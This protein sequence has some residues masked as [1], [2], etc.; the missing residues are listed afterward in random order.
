MNYFTSFQKK[1]NK[2]KTNKKL[3]IY[4]YKQMKIIQNFK[5]VKMIIKMMSLYIIKIFNIKNGKIIQI[6]IVNEII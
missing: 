1:Q 4:K 6:N 2:E 5:R 3:R